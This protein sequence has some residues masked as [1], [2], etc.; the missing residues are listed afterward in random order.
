ML[1]GAALVDSEDSPVG[2]D[3]TDDEDEE[4]TDDSESAGAVDDSTLVDSLFDEVGCS[5]WAMRTIWVF[6]G[7]LSKKY[8]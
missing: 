3:V 8:F 1:L 5:L 2:R 7:Q 6:N 4:D